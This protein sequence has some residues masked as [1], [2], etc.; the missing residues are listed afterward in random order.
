MSEERRALPIA[1]IYVSL[2][3]EIHIFCAPDDQAMCH[4]VRLIDGAISSVFLFA[5]ILVFAPLSMFNLMQI[6]SCFSLPLCFVSLCFSRCLF[7]S[8]F[9]PSHLCFL[10][11]WLFIRCFGGEG[12]GVKEICSNLEGICLSLDEQELFVADSAQRSRPSLQPRGPVYLRMWGSQGER[13]R[14][15]QLTPLMSR[16][17]GQVKKC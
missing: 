10:S 14:A 12:S 17:Q 11:L 15:T 5:Y 3:C 4:S 13:A 2:V 9:Q 1:I 8:V 6:Q 7:P 16:S